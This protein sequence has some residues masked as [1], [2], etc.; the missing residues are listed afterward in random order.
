MHLRQIFV[1][2]IASVFAILA[3]AQTAVQTT[4]SYPQTATQQNAPSPGAAIANSP[5]AY[6]L[7]H[8]T[9]PQST[10]NNAAG[11]GAAGTSL[12]SPG[13]SG[14]SATVIVPAGPSPDA[15]VQ[16]REAKR[17]AKA[18]YKAKKKAAKRQYQAQKK[19]AKGDYRAEKQQAD[20]Q[21]DSATT[22]S[23]Q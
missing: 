13:A 19:A 5:Q 8:A 7:P 18:E 9:A 23:G 15:I 16:E 3:H 22:S 4:P 11:N 12:P 2:T 10:G 20:V 14:G 17:A 21:R 6:T 1:G